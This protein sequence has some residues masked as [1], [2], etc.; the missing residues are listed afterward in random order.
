MLTGTMGDDVGGAVGDD[1]TPVSLQAYGEANFSQSALWQGFQDV[2]DDSGDLVTDYSVTSASGFDY[3]QPATDFVP[4]PSALAL[5]PVLL[6]LGL[7]H[8]RTA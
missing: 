2:T 3:T 6:F 5:I 1:F 7:R 4:E 8:K